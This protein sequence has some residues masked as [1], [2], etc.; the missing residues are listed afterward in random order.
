MLGF[1]APLFPAGAGSI[2]R[3]LATFLTLCGLTLS[4]SAGHSALARGV[5][6]GCAT[7]YARDELAPWRGARH[8]AQLTEQEAWLESGSRVAEQ[9]RRV[10]ARLTRSKTSTS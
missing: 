2:W 10:R 9:E 5:P 7:W 6:S 1:G 3:S 8:E 4:A